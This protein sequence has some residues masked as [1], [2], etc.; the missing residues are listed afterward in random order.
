MSSAKSRLSA[1]ALNPADIMIPKKG[2]DLEKW[3]VVACDQYTSDR[4][5]W[6]RV[7]DFVESSPSTLDL[8]YPEV[9]LEDGNEE[10]VIESINSKMKE[11]VE[12]GIFQT[13]ENCFFLI[14]RSVNNTHRWGLVGSLDLE[15]YD[16]SVDSTSLIRATEGT[17][18]SRIPPRKKIRENAPLELPHIMV[19][20]NDANRTL[21][22]PF[23]KKLDSL[24]KVYETPLME[25]GGFLEGYLI[26]GEES[27]DKIATALE[28]LHSSLDKSNPLLFAMGDGNHSLATAKSCWEDIKKNLSEEEIKTHPSRFALVEI[29]NIHDEGLEFEPIHRVLFNFTKDKFDNLLSAHCS[30]FEVSSY[31][32]NDELQK[33]IE[34]I[35]GQT[36]G[37]A[38]K[39]D[40]LLL[41]KLNTPDAAIAAGTIQLILD[42]IIENNLCSLDYIHGFKDTID[43]GVKENNLALL[44]P[45]VSKHT[46]FDAIIKDKALPRKTFS[47]GE[48]NEKRYYMEARALS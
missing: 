19:L 11:Y 21:I 15:K 43:L 2:I 44:M 37:L 27:F 34:E 29:E 41:Y 12:N 18:L 40:G 31:S 13:Y 39:E 26:S 45:D 33:A 14:K 32:T 1:L 17:I 24:T 22:E 48:A 46:F 8:I 5:Y 9:Y 35:D 38:T 3:A 23:T 28:N 16:F 4:E 30:S 7:Q 10:K 20:I 36:F 42:E 25:N 6:K 47:M